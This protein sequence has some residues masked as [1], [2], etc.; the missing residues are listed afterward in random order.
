MLTQLVP[1]CPCPCNFSWT[2]QTPSISISQ[3]G[4][5]YELYEADADIGHKHLG[6][7]FTHGGERDPNSKRMRCVGVPESKIEDTIAKLVPLGYKVCNKICVSVLR[8]IAEW[9]AFRSELWKRWKQPR[10]QRQHQVQ[11]RWS[12]DVWGA[13]SRLGRLLRSQW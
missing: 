4:K 3:V 13:C 11:R 5:F 7:N 6:L 12:L 10:L 2:N 9:P 8:S 1:M